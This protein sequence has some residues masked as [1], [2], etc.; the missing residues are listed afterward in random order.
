MLPYERNLAAFRDGRHY[1]KRAEKPVTLKTDSGVTLEVPGPRILAEVYVLPWLRSSVIAYRSGA[2]LLTRPIG[3]EEEPAAVHQ[4]DLTKELLAALQSFP[5]RTPS[6]AGRPYRDLRLFVTEASDGA[7]SAYLGDVVTHTR[8]LLTEWR[9]SASRVER[10]P[11][12]TAAERKATSRERIRREEE[13][14]ARDWLEGF[15]SGWDGD[16]E[17]PAP[18][19]R[20]IASELYGLAA[21][22]IGDAVEDADDARAAKE[23]P[24]TLPDGTPY[25]VPRQRVFYA[26]ADELLGARRRGAKGSAMVY[27]I[28]GA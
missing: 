15:L 4:G 24:E 22:A 25:R 9:P 28:P 13:P 19:S 21:D 2:A 23:E 3:S 12:K 14:S 17:A 10:G 6:E 27:V 11:A 1:T 20:W 5:E 26:V 8:R 18:G 16:V 7:R